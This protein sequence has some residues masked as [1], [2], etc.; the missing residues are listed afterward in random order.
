MNRTIPL[1]AAFVLFQG[2]NGQVHDTLSIQTCFYLSAKN[3]PQ[4]RQREIYSKSFEYKIKNI[5]SNWLPA[6]GFNAQASY[7][8]ET[9]NFSDLLANM[10]VTIP[11]LPLDQYR[12]GADLNQQLYDGGLYRA[13]KLLEKAGLQSD[14]QQAESEI[15]GIKQ[16]VN[17]VY[18]SLLINQKSREAI[19]V[20]VNELGERK[21][22][23]QAGLDHGTVLPE[24]VMALDAEEL[25]LQQKLAELDNSKLQ[26]LNMLSILLDTT[27]G[28]NTALVCP[29]M[30]Q[31]IS[32]SLSRP[33]LL[34]F[35]NQK[36]KIDANR[37]LITAFDMP[38][39]FAYSQAAYG[40]PGYNFASRDFHAF[41]SIGLGMKWNFLNYGDNRR[42][43]K[44]LDLQKDLIDIKKE[45]FDDQINIQLGTENANIE[46]YNQ[47]LQKDEQILALR[48]KIKESSFSK[49]SNGVITSTDYLTELNEEL[50]ARLQYE[51]HKIMKIQAAYNFLLIKGNL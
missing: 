21:K 42:Q 37:K 5:N 13:Q 16:Q 7:N 36:E 8:S 40:R 10:P 28:D 44:M 22:I 3:A 34:V 12:I 43:K 39:L 41:Y 6:I 14:I 45:S 20:S 38:K 19:E 24:N 33:E 48:K 27:I 29:I 2:V 23:L 4:S 35:E 26:M 9:V 1:I 17:Q 30:P 50:L 49:L 51:S 31:M 18:F 46:K 32:G 25:K 15:L 11:E 47:L